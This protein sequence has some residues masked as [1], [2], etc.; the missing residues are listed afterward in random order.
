MISLVRCALLMLL[1]GLVLGCGPGSTA[2]PPPATTPA[3]EIRT[4]LQ[5]IVDSGTKGSEMMTIQQN[6]EKLAETE[7]DQADKLRAEFQK[8]EAAR[9]PQAPAQAKKMIEML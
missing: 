8:L 6:I 4:N 2:V 7:P 5:Y 1:T 9:G 3:D